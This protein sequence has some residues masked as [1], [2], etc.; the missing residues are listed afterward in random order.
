MYAAVFEM[1][2]ACSQGSPESDMLA[3]S[4][5][6]AASL[7]ERRGVLTLLFQMSPEAAPAAAEM[8]GFD[9]DMVMPLLQVRTRP[10]VVHHPEDGACLPARMS[11]QA[12]WTPV[13]STLSL[14]RHP[15]SLCIHLPSSSE[16]LVSTQ[17]TDCGMTGRWLQAGNT[18]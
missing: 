10:H 3:A 18:S 4:M 14:L 9:P 12:A 17:A 13:C 2:L 6:K 8:L 7:D 1:C 16:C 5:K 15:L 11:W